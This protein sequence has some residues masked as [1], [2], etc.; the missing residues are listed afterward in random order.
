MHT[1][2]PARTHARVD[3]SEGDRQ[4]NVDDLAPFGQIVNAIVNEI[5]NGFCSFSR[6][7]SSPLTI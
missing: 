2:T 7:F 3:D 1:P 6:H 5:V 4:R